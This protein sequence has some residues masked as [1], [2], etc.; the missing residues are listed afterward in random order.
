MSVV[1]GKIRKMEN[2]KYKRSY[3]GFGNICS[4]SFLPNESTCDKGVYINRAFIQTKFDWPKVCFMFFRNRK[5]MLKLATRFIF[6]FPCVWLQ[7]FLVSEETYY[8]IYHLDYSLQGDR[9]LIL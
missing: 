5:S 4:F 3:F 9:K 1:N 8:C 6:P 2:Q 7:H